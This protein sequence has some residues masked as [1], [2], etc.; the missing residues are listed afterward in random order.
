MVLLLFERHDLPVADHLLDH[1]RHQASIGDAPARIVQET[2]MAEEHE[3]PP[4]ESK[5]TRSKARWAREGRFLTGK[6]FTG[7]T[8]TGKTF[9][10][11]TCTDK[12]SRPGAQRLWRVGCQSNDS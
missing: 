2:D 12:T 10:D 11:K 9:I 4:P 8:F 5:L 1:A 6:T 7:K 3:P